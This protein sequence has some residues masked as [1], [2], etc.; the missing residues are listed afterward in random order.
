M[1]VSMTHPRDPFAIPSQYWNRYD[2]ATIEMPR[3]RIA[4]ENLDPHSRRL[5][6]GCGMDLQ[7]IR[8]EQIRAARRASFRAISYVGDQI[9]SLLQALAG[10]PLAPPKVVLVPGG[11]RAI[12][13]ER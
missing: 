11:P 8:D 7:P 9:G 6:H 13:R 4:V 5:R 2:E 1:V 3:V 10:A 12:L